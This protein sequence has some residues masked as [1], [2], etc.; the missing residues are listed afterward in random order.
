MGTG[1][2]GRM[3]ASSGACLSLSIADDFTVGEDL[4]S[5]QLLA[6]SIW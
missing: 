2:E 5:S 1:R 4:A 3:V 6:L